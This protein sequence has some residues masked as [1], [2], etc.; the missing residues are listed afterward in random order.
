MARRDFLYIGR[1]RWVRRK[2]PL[3]LTVHGVV[4]GACLLAVQRVFRLDAR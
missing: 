4:I 2:K 1:G 3:R